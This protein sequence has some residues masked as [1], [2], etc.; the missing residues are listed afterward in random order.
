MIHRTVDVQRLTRLTCLLAWGCSALASAVAGSVQVDVRDGADKPLADA[1][2]FLD[3]ADAKRMVKPMAA[4]DMGQAQKQFTPRV[5]AITVGT[6]VRFPNRDTVRHHVYSFSPAKKFELK[7]YIGT[8]ATPVLF[9][10]PGIVV[11]GCNIHDDMAGWIVVTESPYLGQTIGNG[12]TRIDNVPAGSYTLRVWHA[13]L[14]VGAAA[15]AQTVVVPATGTLNSTV[16]MTGL[17]P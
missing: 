1:V 2:V 14:P 3:S 5:L 7:L 11:L 17:V 12:S 16:R 9:D 13:N 10:K 8:P 4:L 15:M 6:E